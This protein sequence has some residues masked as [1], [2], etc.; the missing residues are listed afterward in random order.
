MLAVITDA[1][2]WQCSRSIFHQPNPEYP[3]KMRLQIYQPLQRKYASQSNTDWPG[4]NS[5][6]R[7]L[8]LITNNHSWTIDS[9]LSIFIL[10]PRSRI[11]TALLEILWPVAKERCPE[12]KMTRYSL[13]SPAALTQKSSQLT[14]SIKL[15]TT[16]M[17]TAKYG[18][19]T[20]IHQWW[21]FS[22]NSVKS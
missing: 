21:R 14:A 3:W 17:C 16:I 12:D 2:L 15:P 10:F 19:H 18:G 4:D 22:W 20:T 7:N 13:Y 1:Q 6:L 9:H 11:F 8:A 5:C